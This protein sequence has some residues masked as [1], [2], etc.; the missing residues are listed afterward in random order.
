MFFLSRLFIYAVVSMIGALV[1]QY[2]S[3]A[4]CYEDE[5]AKLKGPERSFKV[6]NSVRSPPCGGCCTLNT[7]QPPS[8]EGEVRYKTLMGYTVTNAERDIIRSNGDGDVSVVHYEYDS[9]GR[10]SSVYVKISCRSENKAAGAGAWRAVEIRGTIQKHLTNDDLEA[11]NRRC[12][13]E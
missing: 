8:R 3:Y 5:V 6:S 1:L 13:N 9:N 12:R 10:V 4:A 11:A 2:Q 7:C